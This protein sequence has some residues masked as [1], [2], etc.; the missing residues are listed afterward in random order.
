MPEINIELKEIDELGIEFKAGIRREIISG[1]EEEV[2]FFDTS[3]KKFADNLL[4]KFTGK[5]KD[6]V[7]FFVGINEDTRD[8]SP[9]PL[10]RTRNEFHKSLREHLSQNNVNVL[11]S[12]TVPISDKEGI[13]IIVLQKENQL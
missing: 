11:L 9:I 12:E 6:T 7:I 10:N 4:E 13:L 3:P 1:K 8:F 5:R 2:G